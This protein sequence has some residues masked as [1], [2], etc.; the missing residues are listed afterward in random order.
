[1]REIHVVWQKNNISVPIQTVQQNQKPVS[2][3][4]HVAKIIHVNSCTAVKM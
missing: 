2:F 1:M 3:R 4:E